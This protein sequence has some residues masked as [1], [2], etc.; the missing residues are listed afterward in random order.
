MSSP[1]S[2]PPP[3]NYISPMLQHSHAT[4]SSGAGTTAAGTSPAPYP[5]PSS[6][7]IDRVR[8]PN[9]AKR[10]HIDPELDDLRS[11]VTRDA[12]REEAEKV[13][14]NNQPNV[15]R[16]VSA[17]VLTATSKGSP[18]ASPSMNPSSKPS[19]ATRA[20]PRTIMP[21]N[22]SIDSTVSS[23][24]S[25]SVSQKVNGTNAYRVSQEPSGPQDIASLI[26]TA[27]SPAAA[28][29]KLINEKNQAASHNAQLWRLVEKQRAM[30]L[31]L[32]KDLEKSL[33][34][35]ERYRRKL[36]DHLA[37]SESASSLPTANQQLEELVRREESQSP[38]VAED[39]LGAAAPASIRDISLE[40]RKISDTSDVASF[41]AGRSDTPQEN[42]NAP[43]S[44]QPATPQSTNSGQAAARD[45]EQMETHTEP[46][47]SMERRVPAPIYVHPVSTQP[48]PLS[49]R[50]QEPQS[51]QQTQSP[52]IF[53]HHKNNSITSTAS[54][55]PSA[56]SFSSA[57]TSRKAP[58]AP[59]NLSPK[60]VE[61]SDITNNIIDPSDSEYEEDPDSARSIQLLRGR[62]KTREEDDREREMQARE[63][64]EYRS[65]SKKSKSSKSKQ[66]SER[67]EM[68][69]NVSV[70]AAARTVR[71]E[72]APE[73]QSQMPVYQ[74]KDDSGTGMR[75]RA[76]ESLPKS[77][78]APSLLSPGLPMSPRP[79]DRPMNSP[80][81]RAPNKL[82]NSIPMSP[83]VWH[84][85]VCRFHH[86]R[87]D[88]LFRCHH[89][90]RSRSPHH[91]LLAQKP[92]CLE[93]HNIRV[94]L[95]ISLSL[96]PMQVLSRNAL[97]RQASTFQFQRL[98]VR[99]TK[100]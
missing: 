42:S 77:N 25:T 99:Y 82:L 62:R 22:P 9:P 20:D 94:H 67:P 4:H 78:T 91:I 59:L 48:A 5:V 43:S 51:S 100:A 93:H 21:R 83:Q 61:P 56:A 34:E 12:L 6:V 76:L 29:Q 15:Q 17:P 52:A 86:E 60:K 7:P 2:P 10:A 68:L 71:T 24:S 92:I 46:A 40:S 80:M 30:I 33:K 96:R 38:A 23:A 19:I 27:G 45:T 87:Q 8:A 65:Q 84:G 28:I 18:P 3:R 73:P 64:E 95:Q 85:Q 31:G 50:I 47:A 44:A 81:P 89:K 49:P 75:E 79:G 14:S 35:K 98:L 41:T 55:P 26:A 66:P 13:A 74:S 72:V 69:S 88:N 36:K 63:E 70:S 53:G 39:G 54:P 1:R 90:R 11:A 97:L 37:H 57:K 16:N 32:N 58:P